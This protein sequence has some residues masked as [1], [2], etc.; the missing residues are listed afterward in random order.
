MGLYTL[1]SVRS[2]AKLLLGARVREFK[3]PGVV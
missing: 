2:R 1:S 3:T